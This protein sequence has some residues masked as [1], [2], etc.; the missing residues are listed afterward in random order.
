MLRNTTRQVAPNYWPYSF[1]TSDMWY[2]KF[3]HEYWCGIER[4]FAV[5][6]V[7]SQKSSGDSSLGHLSWNRETR[8]RCTI[9]HIRSLSG[10]FVRT[11]VR[12]PL[13]TIVPHKSISIFEN[14]HA[15]GIST[16]RGR[17]KSYAFSH[18]VPGFPPT[19]PRAYVACMQILV[20]VRFRKSGFFSTACVCRQRFSM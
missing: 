8:A 20:D 1:P 12:A 18:S 15:N 13:S 5:P 10:R 17:R 14:A 2:G 16:F 7:G 6:L 9:W 19:W 11:G 4:E 3:Y